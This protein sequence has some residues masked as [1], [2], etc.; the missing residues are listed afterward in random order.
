MRIFSL[1][2]GKNIIS[3][4][5]VD[6]LDRLAQVS[7]VL[8][9]LHE[10]SQEART[11]KAFDLV[12]IEVAFGEEAEGVLKNFFGHEA[13]PDSY[14]LLGRILLQDTGVV[15]EGEPRIFFIPGGIG[16]HFF[17]DG[18]HLLKHLLI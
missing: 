16:Q 1:Q 6:F 18:H 12:L 3:E 7:A 2:V 17:H 14:F 5:G 9:Q 13:A 8:G 15:C 4:L 11:G 10:V